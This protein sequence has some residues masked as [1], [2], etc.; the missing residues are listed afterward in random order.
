LY[1][2]FLLVFFCTHTAPTSIY[3]LSLHDALPISLGFKIHSQMIL[4]FHRI[5][6]HLRAE[7]LNKTH[8]ALHSR[9]GRLTGATGKGQQLGGGTGER[10]P[11][12]QGEAIISAEGGGGVP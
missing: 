1:Y 8:Q 9:A 10:L 2:T 7:H 5:Q 12:T 6:L 4:I 11:H 3:T